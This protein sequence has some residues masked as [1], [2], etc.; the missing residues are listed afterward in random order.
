MRDFKVVYRCGCL[1]LEWWKAPNEWS[2]AGMDEECAKMY[3]ILASR[4][5]SS[6]K[7]RDRLA[8]SPNPKGVFTISSGC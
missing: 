6:L 8:W 7:G 3:G 2:I 1:E 5:C 4:H